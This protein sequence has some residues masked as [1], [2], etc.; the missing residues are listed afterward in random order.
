MS[1]KQ[2]YGV[3]WNMDGKGGLDYMAGVEVSSFDGMP[4]ELTQFTLAPQRYAVFPHTAHI[5]MI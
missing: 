3:C 2:C 5:S 4:A 1:G